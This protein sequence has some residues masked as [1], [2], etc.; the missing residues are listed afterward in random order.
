MTESVDMTDSLPLASM[1]A[2]VQSLTIGS[3]LDASLAGSAGRHIS[4]RDQPPI[5]YRDFHERVARLASVLRDH[6]V[7]PGDTVAMLDWDSDRYL[8]CYF[9]VPMMGAI[10]QTVNIRLSP[11]QIRY[12]LQQSRARVLIVH[13]DF[14]PLIE[15]LR[16]ELPDARH[17]VLIADGDADGLPIWASGS[18]GDLLERSPADFRFDDT[19]DENSVATTFYTTGTTGLPKGVCFT[20]R[21]LVL[22]SLSFAAAL[23]ADGQ[24]GYGDVYMPLTPMFHVHAWGFPYVATM[25]GLTQVYPGRY[26]PARIVDLHKSHGVTLSHC[27]PTVLGMVMDAAGSRG[28]SLEGWKMLI[29]GAALSPDM[30]EDAQAI[31]LRI[32]AGYGMSETGPV[33]SVMRASALSESHHSAARSGYPIP[34]VTVSVVDEAM[35]PVPRDDRSQGELVVRSP[36]GTSGYIGDAVASEQLWRGGWLHTQDV[37]TLHEDGSV[38]IRDRL[39]D[40]IKSGGE[41]ICSQTLEALISADA[42]VAHVAVVGVPHPQWQERPVALVV[43]R[44]GAEPDVDRIMRA[45][46]EAV[47]RGE[48]SR[49]AKLDRIEIVDE[50]PLTSVGKID[51]KAIRASL[52]DRPTDSGVL[53][54]RAG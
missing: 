6:G 13:R 26:E 28:I 2:R 16:H 32:L 25:L 33:V 44:K 15:T 29:G 42:D 1:V 9:A 40:V 45:L 11:D 24:L 49:Y 39:K 3:L 50:L 38:Q 31:G 21:Q 41:W 37:A 4:Y 54:A 43:P 52:Q 34:L 14:A 18:Y 12:T 22:H 17:Y 51:K 53:A 20:H 35:N 30:L 48:I 27:V 5:S 10:L 23:G 47:E 8:A 19:L 36:W 7:E 46:D